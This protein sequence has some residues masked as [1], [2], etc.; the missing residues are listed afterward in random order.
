MR[1]LVTAQ[2]V[3]PFVV[4]FVQQPKEVKDVVMKEGH[5]VAREKGTFGFEIMQYFNARILVD[6]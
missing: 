5:Q 1:P 6:G 2:T 4:I 3:F